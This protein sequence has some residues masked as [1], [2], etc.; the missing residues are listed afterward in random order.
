[1]LTNA[2]Y[3]R[4]LRAFADWLDDHPEVPLQ[5]YDLAISGDESDVAACARALG[6][7]E[8]RHGDSTSALV[9]DFAGLP[10]SIVYFRSA[11]CER[12]VV[13]HEEVPE[14]VIPAHTREI[15]EW[16]CHSILAEREPA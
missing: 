9:K 4:G 2:E 14:R 13:G 12:R 3:A 1:M 6:A 16:D 5:L 10:V 11:V 15:V 7:C 8:K